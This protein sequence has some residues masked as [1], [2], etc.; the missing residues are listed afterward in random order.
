MPLLF[1][2]RDLL[3][4]LARRFGEVVERHHEHADALGGRTR[5]DDE[6]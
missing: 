2:R 4:E 5:I 1:R 6:A 3:R